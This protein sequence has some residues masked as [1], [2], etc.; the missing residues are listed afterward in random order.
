VLSFKSIL[1]QTKKPVFLAVVITLLFAA[2]IMYI[3]IHLLHD[4]YHSSAF[5][6]GVFAQ[7]LKNTL[8]G[9]ILYSSAI[10]GSQFAPHFSPVLLLLVPIYWLFPHVQTLLVVQ[11]LLL[12][13]GGYMI[14]VL[15]R[16]YKYSHRAS[17]ILEGLYFINPLLW[18]VALF[19]FHEVAFA[20]PALLLMFLGLKKKDW[21]FFGIGL[22]IALASKEDV[23]IVIGVFGAVLMIADYW[24]N[25]RVEKT[26]VIVFFAAILAYGI[27]IVVSHLASQGESPRM[28]TYLTSRYAYVGEPLSQAIPLVTTTIFSTGSLFLIIAYLAPFAFLPILS[29]KCCIPALVVLL[30]GILSTNDNQ[31][32]MLMQYTA[33]AI[34]FLFVAFKEVLPKVMANKD[35]QSLIQKTKNRV[36]NYS[37]VFLVIISLAVISEGRIQKASLPNAHDDA[38]NQIIALIPDNATV[39]ASNAIFS[40]LVS[41]T[42]VF[43]DAQ[44]GTKM[45]TSAGIV[46]SDWGFPDKNTEYVILDTENISM[47]APDI[48]LLKNRYTQIKILDGVELY[49]LNA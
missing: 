6:L 3:T 40:H 43:L 34:P 4:S 18:G 29:P 15:A 24:K 33:A 16:E 14:Y 10:G 9:Q 25:K 36:V 32:T 39:T 21:V 11:A 1:G 41:R 46:K 19:D 31:H 38:I 22:L 30:E 13:F 7:E 37:L 5:D 45:Q 49:R 27:G 44:E 12:A 48:I 8:Q 35:I 20:I 23:V 42:D 47:M 2:V 28:L 26:S 17:L